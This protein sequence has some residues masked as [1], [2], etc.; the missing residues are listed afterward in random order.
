MTVTQNV[1]TLCYEP[2]LCINCE[3]CIIVCPHAV[4]A[5][6]GKVVRVANGESCM[7]CGACQVNCPVAAIKVDSGVG[8]AYALMWSAIRGGG[9]AVCGPGEGSCC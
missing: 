3:M 2:G 9:P 5:P 7:E 8:C 1:N 4:F 6:D